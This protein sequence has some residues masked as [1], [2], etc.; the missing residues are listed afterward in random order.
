MKPRSIKPWFFLAAFAVSVTALALISWDNKQHTAGVR[1]QQQLPSDTPQKKKTVRDK[2]IRDLD[3]ALEELN[4]KDFEQEM[5]NAIDEANR[6]LREIDFEKI[7]KEVE[8]AMQNVDMDKI[9]AEIQNSLKEID[10]EKLNKETQEA[11]KEAQ[12]SLR[13]IDFQKFN[14]EVERSLKE[15]DFKKISKTAREAVEKIDWDKMKKDME[16]VKKVNLDK[17]SDEMQKVQEELKDLNPRI[18]KEL[19]KAKVEI[20]KAKTEIKE[21]KELVDG[22]EKDGLL[23]KKQSYTIVHKNGVLTVNGKKV[24]DDIYAKYRSILEKHSSFTMKKD[25]DNFTIDD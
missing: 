17:L 13:E 23:D 5:K 19:E 11:M 2:K 15:I 25:E 6:S 12:K 9:N 1:Q 22:L 8:K 16:S 7:S 3:E 24:A 4:S 14:D 21:Y 20:E 18:H 10:F